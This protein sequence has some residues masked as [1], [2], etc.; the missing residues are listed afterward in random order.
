VNTKIPSAI[1]NRIRRIVTSQHLR[2][3]SRT[4]RNQWGASVRLWNFADENNLLVSPEAGLDDEAALDFLWDEDE[5][6]AAE[7]YQQA[8]RATK[9]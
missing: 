4:R 5:E 3:T 1:A 9:R 8:V 6:D 2:A 7:L